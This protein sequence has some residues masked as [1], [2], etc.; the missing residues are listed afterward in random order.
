MT[1][2][3]ALHAESAIRQVEDE[4]FDK[5]RQEA[6]QTVQALSQ[7]DVSSRLPLL[8]AVEQEQDL[9]P[10]FQAAERIR[11]TSAC[12]VVFG[13][14][15]SSLGGQSLLALA[16]DAFGRPLNGPDVRFYDNVDPH[17]LA[18]LEQCVNISETSFIV[19]SKSGTTMET[20]SQF[21]MLVAW[22]EARNAGN[23]LKER[24]W[25]VTDEGSNPL[26]NLAVELGCPLLNGFPGVGGRYS[27]LTVFG[28]LPAAVAGMDVNA[29][30][31][32]AA[33]VVA[34]CRDQSADASPV[35]GS[36]LNAALLDSA[37]AN[38]VM[39]PYCDRLASFS[40]WFKQL[41]GESLGKNGVGITPH[42]ALGTVDQHSQLQLYLDGPKDK[43]FTLVQVES[44]GQGPKLAPAGAIHSALGYLKGKTIGDVLDAEFHATAESLINQGCPVRIITVPELNERSYGALLMHYMIETIITGKLMAID[45]FDQPAVDEGKRIARDLLTSMAA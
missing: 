42:N 12:V 24:V 7:S 1:L 36:A 41:V 13:T 20:A 15:G 35:L 18:S 39:M 37:Y 9:P 28:L 31:A 22:L 19:F 44:K 26:R 6:A 29:L 30:R 23:A 43:H 2:P 3:F 8:R 16:K 45:P 33:E 14:G 25:V 34:A 40:A 27:V 10:V 4:A 5:Y 38:A 17:T 21:L 32:G 11:D